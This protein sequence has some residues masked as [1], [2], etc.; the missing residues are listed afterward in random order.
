MVV[1]AIGPTGLETSVFEADTGDKLVAAPL[2]AIAVS[3]SRTGDL[4]GAMGGQIT[5]YDL[6]TL[7]PISTYPAARGEVNSLQFST[8]ATTLLA[9]SND[10]TVSLFDVATGRSWAIASPRRRRSS[11]PAPCDPTVAQSP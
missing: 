8:D 3:V 9:T 7:E 10:Q 11:P 1:S 4:V 2:K 6:D 5:S